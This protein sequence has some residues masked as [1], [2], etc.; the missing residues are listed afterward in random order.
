MF[1]LLTLLVPFPPALS[2][3]PEQE[4]TPRHKQEVLHGP[5]PPLIAI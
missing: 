1:I 5:I 4:T 3:Q 2:Y